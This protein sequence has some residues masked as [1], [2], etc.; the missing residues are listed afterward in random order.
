[1]RRVTIIGALDIYARHELGLLAVLRY[2]GYNVS[3]FVLTPFIN[4]VKVNK[5]RIE[6]DEGIT[7]VSIVEVP[8]NYGARPL[9]KELSSHVVDN[10]DA[11]ILTSGIPWK[12]TFEIYAHIRRYINAPVVTRFWSIRAFKLI[13][14]VMHGSYRDIALFIPSLMINY[15]KHIFS[16][17]VIYEDNY[18]YEIGK[19]MAPHI[20]RAKAYPTPGIPKDSINDIDENAYGIVDDIINQ[21][22]GYVL[23]STILIK[24]FDV[25]KYEAVPHALLLYG[26]ARRNPEIPIIVFGSTM[27]EFKR[28]FPGLT[29]KIPQNLIFIGKGLSNEFIKY[30]YQKATAVVVYISNRSVSNRFL[31]TIYFGKPVIFNSTALKLYPEI[32]NAIDLKSALANNLNEYSSKVKTIF[33][34]DEL[35]KEISNQIRKTY[36]LLFSSRKNIKVL[37]SLIEDV[38]FERR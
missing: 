7:Q 26:I 38:L 4:D 28:A 1:M 17:A 11:V 33:E 2:Y 20:P 25:E 21:Y 32:S 29:N 22:G 5:L 15:F 31:E 8:L 37:N 24:A 16:D 13:D 6:F 23:A 3:A 30:L 27:D 14:N 18:L 19:Y 35:R 10:S 36:E 9:I 34:S 12:S